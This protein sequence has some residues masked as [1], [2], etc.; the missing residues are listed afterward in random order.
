[1]ADGHGSSR[2]FR[3]DIGSEKAV[4]MAEKHVASLV[5]DMPELSGETPIQ[6]ALANAVRAIING[7]FAAVMQHEA[8]NPLKDD[9]RLEGVA[10]K[11]KDRYIDDVDYRCHAY[12][13]TLMVAVMSDAY[14]FGLHVGDGKCVA[15]YEDGSWGLPIPWDDRCT[16]NTTTSIC[17]DDSLSGFR[18]WFGFSN[19]S[20]GYMEYG[21]GVNGQDKDYVKEVKSR[22]VAIFIG[23][24]GVEDSYPRMDN[25]KYVINFYRKRVISLA[26]VGFDA[27][28]EELDGLAKRFAD[29][30][31]TDDVSIAGIVGDFTGKEAMIA[32]MKSE[33]EVHEKSEMAVAKRRDADEKK[34]ALE[35]IQA[36]RQSA[37]I[38]K[39]ALTGKL[40]AA[41][42][43]CDDLQA[44]IQ[45]LKTT[46]SEE[47]DAEKTNRQEVDLSKEKVS[48]LKVEFE[49][50]SE[51]LRK[52]QAAVTQAENN[53][54]EAAKSLADAKKERD[55]KKKNLKKERSDIVNGLQ[56]LEV[57][58]AAGQ[59]IS[60]IKVFTLPGSII[61]PMELIKE[62]RH[63]GIALNDK[64]IR[65][66]DFILAL[67][68]AVK[69]RSSKVAE[70]EKN[71]E[72][73]RKETAEQRKKLA[74]I[75]RN[76]KGIESSYEK[77]Q[78]EYNALYAKAQ[79]IRSSLSE[80]EGDL[81]KSERLS[82]Q[83]QAE[84][85]KLNDEMKTLSEQAES[86]IVKYNAIEAAYEKAEQAAAELEK[87]LKEH[88]VTL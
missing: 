22:P 18:Y 24:D 45:R 65:K 15:L 32:R 52:Q 56:N 55:R 79:K 34:M 9:I 30:E 1:V 29:R 80:H 84:L 51:A 49:D 76:K 63:R 16:F 19:G 83:K 50:I 38:I 7:W 61:D 66:H 54:K 33:S 70:T 23:S 74:D 67:E 3:S 13:T 4:E 68:G 27:F 36:R 41:K 26:E 46:L 25:D 35:A 17:D 75:E 72:S 86:Q 59:R 64:I 48:K 87:K 14:W 28:C 12:G 53:E 39:D 6:I 47:R 85:D 81:S 21:Y 5:K 82:T 60:I 88:G 40:E 69:D 58:N 78:S 77:A 73:R 11:Y 20:G 8:E 42:R 43:D 44:K 71:A 37:I 2:C 57:T 62:I 31:S 10:Q